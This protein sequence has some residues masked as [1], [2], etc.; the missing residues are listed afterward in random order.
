M[1]M[2]F[3]RIGAAA[4]YEM[5]AEESIEMAHA[6]MKMARILRGENPTPL[7]MEDAFKNICEEYTDVAIC[8]RELPVKVNEDLMC[9]KKERFLQ[10][11]KAKS[12][13]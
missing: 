1:G 13:G 9:R 7:K 6:A 11:W 10:R 4:T 12:E 2:I 8:L 3:D 5:L